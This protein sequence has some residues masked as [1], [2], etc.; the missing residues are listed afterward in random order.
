M[1]MINYNTILSRRGNIKS[2]SF[3]LTRRCVHPDRVVLDG[4]DKDEAVSQDPEDER[5]SEVG[6]EGPGYTHVNV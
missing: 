2:H 5:D 4:R 6:E 1:L 3:S